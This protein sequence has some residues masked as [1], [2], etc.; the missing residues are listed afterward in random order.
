[1][2]SLIPKYINIDL[3]PRSNSEYWPDGLGL[4]PACRKQFRLYV[5]A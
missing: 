1:M 5:K 4:T 3:P 2:I